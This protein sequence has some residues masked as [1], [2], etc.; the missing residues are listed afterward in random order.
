M[1]NIK[2]IVV[3]CTGTDTNVSPSAISNYWRNHL[4]WKNPG[5]HYMIDAVGN[6]TILQ[7]EEKIANGVKGHNRRSVHVSYIGGKKGLDTRTEEQKKTLK[8]VIDILKNRYPKAEVKG[9]CDFRGVTKTCPNF[10]VKKDYG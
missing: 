4:G 7:K 5:Y 10:D 2:Y 9:H 6:L 3:H 8:L 1:R